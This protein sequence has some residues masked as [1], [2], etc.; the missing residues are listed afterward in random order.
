MKKKVLKVTAAVL[1]LLTV[2][3]TAVFFLVRSS[4]EYALWTMAKDVQ[5]GGVEGLKPHLTG[6]ALELVERLDG[7]S[8]SKD[9]KVLDALSSILNVDRLVETMKNELAQMTWSLD[10]VE[11]S[12]DA[13][14]FSLKFNY[15]DKLT[16]VVELDMVRE[17]GVW[18]ISGIGLSDLDRP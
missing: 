15:E 1:L 17:S 10:D 18:K 2:A 11:K 4:P 6:D 3:G 13:A 7:I 5:S 12:A 16:G 8:G 14:E 9:N